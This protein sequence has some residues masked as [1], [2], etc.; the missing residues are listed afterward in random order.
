[1]HGQKGDHNGEQHRA[2]YPEHIGE[3]VKLERRPTVSAFEFGVPPTQGAYFQTTLACRT[4]DR[5]HISPLADSRHNRLYNKD[6]Y[7]QE[8]TTAC[9][10]PYLATI[11]ESAC[12]NFAY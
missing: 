11:N 2:R 9:H 8:T 6:S 7:K 12:L 3:S 10:A 4:N 1:M 5:A